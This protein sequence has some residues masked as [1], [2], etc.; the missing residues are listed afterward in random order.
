MKTRSDFYKPRECL[1]SSFR[2]ISS[3]TDTFSPGQGISSTIELP[4]LRVY[5]VSREEKTKVA[6]NAGRDPA[7]LHTQCAAC[8]KCNPYRELYR[9]FW[10]INFIDYNLTSPFYFCTMCLLM[11][12]VRFNGTVQKYLNLEKTKDLDCNRHQ[13]GA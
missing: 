13:I 6:L 3:G 8:R 5:K 10:S 12:S 11:E 7:L 1:F 2:G 9:I 4:I